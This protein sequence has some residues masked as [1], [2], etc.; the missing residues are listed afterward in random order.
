[1]QY[2]ADL[3]LQVRSYSPAVRLFF[4]SD[5]CFGMAQGILNL[6]LN[7]H[8]L[9]LGYT[10]E[11]VG[12]LQAI[13]AIVMA[14]L[15]I[16]AGLLADRYGKRWFYLAGSY[17]FGLPFLLLP[18]INDF[19]GLVVLYSVHFFANTL[20]FTTEFPILAAE[21]RPEE[22]PALFS[23]VFVNFFTWNSLGT[24]LAG[25]LPRWLPA[26][27][28][29]YAWSLL[30]AGL[31]GV[32]AGV[33]RHGMRLQPEAL[34]PARGPV[35]AVDRAVWQ[36]GALSLVLGAAAAL[37]FNFGNVILK[38]RF[39]LSD[40]Q[41]SPLLTLTGIIGVAGN[42][43]VPALGRKLGQVSGIILTL[44]LAVPMQVACGYAPNLAS[45]LA[46][47]W[48]RG[49]LQSMQM[50]Q[51]SA[52]SM[53]LVPGT[54]RGAMSS[55]QMVG[56]NGGTALAAEVYGRQLAARDFTGPFL[57]SGALAGLAAMLFWLWFGRGK[58]AALQASATD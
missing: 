56:R 48:S 12:R 30:L 19:G 25:G 21:V 18:F 20:M 43:V 22:R 14:V 35:L 26:G 47:F 10:A 42:A 34:A 16:P 46:A 6:Q 2:F 51:T 8:L 44:V 50:P 57:V 31:I 58:A 4:L 17:G 54:G 15:A 29:P 3:Y 7:L 9:Q 23:F 11:H 39:G 40:L 27:N 32:M 41:I 33:I 24:L 55:F 38:E 36:M 37:G 28:T 53:S 1:M 49:L 5:L 52:L 45:Y 13:G